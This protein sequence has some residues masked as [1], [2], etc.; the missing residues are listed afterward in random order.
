LIF[1]ASSFSSL[2]NLLLIQRISAE[3]NTSE[4]ILLGSSGG[5]IYRFLFNFGRFPAFIGSEKAAGVLTIK[6]VVSIPIL[7]RNQGVDPLRM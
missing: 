3:N 6:Y 4:P 2:Q 5:L 1:L 7:N